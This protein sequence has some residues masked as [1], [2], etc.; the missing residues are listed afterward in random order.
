[1]DATRRAIATPVT[2]LSTFIERHGSTLPKTVKVEEGF[3]GTNFEDTLEADQILIFYK[4]ERHNMI[5]ALD[6]FNQEVCVPRNTT[7]NVQLLPFEYYKEYNTVQELV[8]AHQATPYFRVLEDIPS[9]QICSETTLKLLS[10]Q[11]INNFSQCEVVD[12]YDTRQVQMPLQLA[13]RFQPLLDARECYLEEVLA[14]YQLPVNIRFVSQSR[15]SDGVCARALSSLENIHLVREAE[16]EMVFAASVDDQLTLTLFPRTLD[17]SVS[18]GF[19]VTADTCKKIKECRQTLEAS[20]KT[21]KRLDQIAINS[22]YYVACPVRRFNFESL[23]PPSLRKTT[24]VSQVKSKQCKTE[25]ETSINSDAATKRDNL[26]CLQLASKSGLSFKVEAADY[27]NC[28]IDNNFNNSDASKATEKDTDAVP[29]LPPKKHSGRSGL[30]T[31]DATHLTQPKP[32]SSCRPVPKPRKRMCVAQKGTQENITTTQTHTGKSSEDD[33]E[34]T[35]PKLPPRPEFL[36]GSGSD[37][38]EDINVSRAEGPPPPT[39]GTSSEDDAEETCPKLP[40][41]PKFLKQSGIDDK[42]DNNVSR[43]EGLLLLTAGTSS[44]DDVEETCPELPPRPKFLKASGIEDYQDIDD[45]RDDPP[46]LPPR[47]PGPSD[48]GY[49]AYLVVDI[50]DWKALEEKALNTIEPDSALYSEAKDDG[51]VFKQDDPRHLDLSLTYPRDNRTT[52]VDAESPEENEGPYIDVERS[53][54]EGVNGRPYVDMENHER[55][56]VNGIQRDRENSRQVDFIQPDETRAPEDQ[57]NPRSRKAGR[58]NRGDEA[59]KFEEENS[60]DDWPYQEIKEQQPSSPNEHRSKDSVVNQKK[61]KLE[62][63]S[64]NLASKKTDGTSHARP[65]RARIAPRQ[66]GQ[67]DMIISGRRDEDWMDLRD[68]EHFFKLKKQLS[69]AL[70]KQADVQKQV[71][72]TK[73]T[74]TSESQTQQPP[75]STDSTS[76]HVGNAPY[77]DMNSWDKNPNQRGSSGTFCKPPSQRSTQVATRAKGLLLNRKAVDSEKKVEE[78]KPHLLSRAA[79]NIGSGQATYNRECCDLTSVKERDEMKKSDLTISDEDDDDYEECHDRKYINSE[80]AEDEDDDDYEECHDRKYINSEDA[81][82]GIASVHYLQ[83]ENPS[84]EDENDYVNVEAQKN[85]KGL[86]INEIAAQKEIFILE[87]SGFEE[88]PPLPPKNRTSSLR[89]AE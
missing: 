79:E 44:E 60:E 34:E 80:D 71:D 33:A 36:E 65:H 59:R 23:K 20:A 62:S 6:Q 42:E 7:S 19:K 38:E 78:K 66:R 10:D 49:P 89:D 52:I 64:K 68:I 3:C 53:E 24:G 48:F 41:R 51:R 16:V 75:V 45:S 86:G 50:T 13:G 27:E 18:C 17:I 54:K 30:T 43:E 29:P 82:D 46:P 87:N 74:L 15:A 77:M 83:L 14:Q 4:V 58:E 85:D 9:L 37:Y 84:D 22:C 88:P 11:P 28:H 5:I 73:Q 39:S 35:C 70:A 81:K 76:E 55:I 40:P 25:K 67:S 63:P 2:N 8:N 32:Q 72:V 57:E 61:S 47:T 56:G 12:L 31:P 21:L 69:E 1:M 26:H